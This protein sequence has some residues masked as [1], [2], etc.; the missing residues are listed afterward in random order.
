MKR[1]MP[2]ATAVS[3]SMKPCGA[4]P[5]QTSAP[6]AALP[7][8]P[9]TVTTC[10]R[11]PF[12]RSVISPM[13]AGG[14]RAHLSSAWPTTR[15]GIRIASSGRSKTVWVTHGLYRLVPPDVTADVSTRPSAADVPVSREA[16]L[17]AEIVP[18]LVPTTH[19]GPL[20]R[21]LLG[22]PEPGQPVVAGVIGRRIHQSGGESRGMEVGERAHERIALQ[23]ARAALIVEVEMTSASD[24][25]DQRDRALPSPCLAERPPLHAPEAEQAEERAGA[26][27]EDRHRLVPPAAVDSRVAWM[28]GVVQNVDGLAP[29]IGGRIRADRILEP[30]LRPFVLELHHRRIGIAVARAVRGH[31]DHHAGSASR[32]RKEQLGSPVEVNPEDEKPRAAEQHERNGEPVG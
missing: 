26:P 1:A 6:G 24:E 31:L 29:P 8:P 19:T 27:D 32:R 13:W 20:V 15:T 11:E 4:R 25:Q 10:S 14:V 3:C 17:T 30:V 12:V 22:D 7:G 18:R 21:V 9:V 28:N 16:A 23:R 5:S 2:A